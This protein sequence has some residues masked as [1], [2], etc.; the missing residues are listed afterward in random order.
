VSGKR[1]SL[2]PG[3]SIGQQTADFFHITGF[4]HLHL[5]QAPFTLGALLSQNMAVM[6]FGKGEFA[7]SGF[8]EPFG[9]GS[10][11]LDFSHFS[12][13][14]RAWRDS[15]DG[16]YSSRYFDK[17]TERCGHTIIY[18]PTPILLVAAQKIAFSVRIR[19]S[20]PLFGRQY[21]DD[22]STLELRLLCSTAAI[23]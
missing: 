13:R 18:Q 21:H 1:F 4:D 15:R 3:L 12:L 17:K 9:G 20:W 8:A 5:P 19:R 11:C 14:F 7:A 10:V 23:S 2:L 16:L 22:R 6:R